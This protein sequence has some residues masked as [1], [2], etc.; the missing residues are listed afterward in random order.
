M[1]F[2][3]FNNNSLKSRGSCLLSY[4]GDGNPQDIGVFIKI[5]GLF[6]FFIHRLRNLIS[7]IKFCQAKINV[8]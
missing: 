2:L 1:A 4:A 3:C 7:I 6:V 5:V 8:G